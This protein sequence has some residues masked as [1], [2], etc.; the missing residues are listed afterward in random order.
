MSRHRFSASGGRSAQAVAALA[1]PLNQGRLLQLG[2]PIVDPGLLA[3][4]GDQELGDGEADGAG[5]SEHG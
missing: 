5:V 4:G 3:P 1:G 2:K